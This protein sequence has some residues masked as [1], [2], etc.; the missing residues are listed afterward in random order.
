MFV[1]LHGECIKREHARNIFTS[2][3][4]PVYPGRPSRDKRGIVAVQTHNLKGLKHI[5]VIKGI[6]CI[7]ISYGPF[8]Y[9]R[10]GKDC[11][12]ANKVGLISFCALENEGVQ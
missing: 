12:S 10:E 11:L 2:F 4:F 1:T 9:N 6:H 5:T 8:I 3:S 7:Q